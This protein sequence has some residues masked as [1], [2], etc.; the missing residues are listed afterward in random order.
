MSGVVILVAGIKIKKLC[1]PDGRRDMWSF[2]IVFIRCVLLTLPK[3][4]L[5]VVV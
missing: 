5:I 2:K 4:K 1:H 3:L